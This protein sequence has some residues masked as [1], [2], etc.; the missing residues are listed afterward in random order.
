[1]VTMRD[2]AR[3]A[4][5]SLPV[6]SYVINGGPR[7]VSPGTR[8]RVLR[9][10]EELGYKPNRLARGLARKGTLS[11]ALII[12]NISDLF[13]ARLAQAVEEAAYTSGFS[14]LLCNT[15][16]DRGREAAHFNLLTEKRIDGVLLVTSGLDA[17]QLQSVCGEDLPLV[18]LDREIDGAFVDTVIFD[19]Y[20]A[21][22]QSAEHLIQHGYRR[23]A[24]IAG[25]KTLPGA[26]QRVKGYK[27]A[28]KQAG[29]A[30]V[31]KLIRWCD[32]TFDGGL[33]AAS[34]LLKGEVSPQAILACNDEMGAASI[35]AARQAGIEVPRELAVAGIGDSLIGQMVIPQL[36]TVNASVDD[37]G[38]TGTEMLLER[39]GGTAP[40]AQRRVVLDTRLI[41]RGSCGCGHPG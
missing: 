15:G 13:F 40:R 32:Y 14:L 19:N 10:I 4:G 8:S 28:L 26:V 35:H 3:L 20:K 17:G 12:P 5:V 37:M 22:K 1:M 25:P 39:I 7:P 34:G 31:D 2:V 38:R 27:E 21:G 9:A 6:V 33:K 11:I 36:T 23:I 41:I 29:I 18:V 24:C 16:Q 30:P